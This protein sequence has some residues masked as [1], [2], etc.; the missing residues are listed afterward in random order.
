[1][2]VSAKRAA[3]DTQILHPK[4]GDSQNLSKMPSYLRPTPHP[5]RTQTLFMKQALLL[6][7]EEQGFVCKEHGLHSKYF[8]VRGTF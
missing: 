1:M 8:E 4:P 3:D 5:R 7:A 6:T 2:F